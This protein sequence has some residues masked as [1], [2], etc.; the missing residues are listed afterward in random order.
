MNTK[1]CHVVIQTAF[2]GD[3]FLSIPLLQQLRLQYPQDSLILVCK[4]GLGEY[5]FK[6]NIV[7]EVFEVTKNQRGS[8]KKIVNELNK[9]QIKNLFCVHRSI[10]SQLMSLQIKAQ[11]KIGF[12]SLLGFFIFDD[13]IKYHQKWPEAIRQ[14]SILTSINTEIA[15]EISKNEW[16]YLNKTGADGLL[17]PI[18]SFFQTQT[19]SRLGVAKKIALF[20][21]SVWATKK[22]TWQGFAEVANYFLNQGFEVFLM[23]GADEK[24]LCEEIQKLA[25]LAQVLAGHKTITESIEFMRSCALVIS[26]DSAPAHMAASLNIPVI[27]IF[28]P[29]TLD[30]GFRPWS[31]KA[32]V[33]ENTTLDCRPC[34]L[35]GH[36][37]CPLGHHYCMKQIEASKV[38]QASLLLI[39][40]TL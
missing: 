34:G 22:W 30:L 8:Y 6:E 10:R 15:S 39:N 7:D 31:S 19:A 4:K 29:T 1:Y 14:L 37:K 21:G 9:H 35:H 32:I 25:R 16:D 3:L 17:L 38:I 36:Q 2:L 40:R 20:P 28:G 24:N 12:Q 23:G 18:P 26:N 13:H 11:R 27:S 5:F 33:I